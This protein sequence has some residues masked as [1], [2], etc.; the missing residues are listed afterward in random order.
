MITEEEKKRRCEKLDEEI[1]AWIYSGSCNTLSRLKKFYNSI[2]S[3]HLGG[4]GIMERH[5]LILNNDASI[6]KVKDNWRNY[7]LNYPNK[8]NCEICGKDTIV[9]NKE[10]KWICQD[11]STKEIFKQG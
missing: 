10:G 2:I 3:I 9:Y 5:N 1:I 4:E 6:Q 11:C 8:P 7:K